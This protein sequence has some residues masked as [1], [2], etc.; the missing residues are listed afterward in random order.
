MSFINFFLNLFVFFLILIVIGG[1]FK[2]YSLQEL[3]IS[4][5]FIL[6]SFLILLFSRIGMVANQVL[7]YS[8]S[9][10]SFGVPSY[11][12]LIYTI[13]VPLCILLHLLFLFGVHRKWV[14]YY[15]ISGFIALISSIGRQLIAP[16]SESI[17]NIESPVGVIGV[18]YLFSLILIFINKLFTYKGVDELL[19]GW[20][21]IVSMNLGIVVLTVTNRIMDGSNKNLLTGDKIERFSIVDGPFQIALAN[22]MAI[23]AL[24]YLYKFSDRI[25]SGDIGYKPLSK[26]IKIKAD[27]ALECYS[28]SNIWI[29]PIVRSENISVESLHILENIQKIIDCEIHCIIDDEFDSKALTSIYSLSQKTKVKVN[30]LEYLFKNHCRYSFSK[31]SKFIKVCKADFLIQNGFLNDST[32][33]ELARACGFEN[34]VTLF[35]NFKSFLN[36]TI[37]DRK[38]SKDIAV[39]Q[40]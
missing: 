11:I 4:S 33:D 35:N 8:N 28:N 31:Y 16:N 1:W 30:D 3:R 9:S 20:V 38:P 37:R 27:T 15:I 26:I 2:K 40:L 6:I 10:L 21:L 12:L 24:L 18:F 13:L 5:V 19:Y 23:G 36:S 39:S 25:L 14:L 22:I 29:K 17:L 34:R 32:V 7:Y